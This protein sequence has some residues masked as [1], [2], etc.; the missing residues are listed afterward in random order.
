M[1]DFKMCGTCRLQKDNLRDIASRSIRTS[2]WRCDDC[3]RVLNRINRMQSRGLLASEY[4][5]LNNGQKVAFMQNAVDLF[6][7]DINRTICEHLEKY[8]EPRYHEMANAD[9]PICDITPP[10]GKRKRTI[11]SENGIV[12]AAKKKRARVAPDGKMINLNQRQRGNRDTAEQKL[13]EACVD[14]EATIMAANAPNIKPEIPSKFLTKVAE[15]A[16]GFKQIIQAVGELKEERVG[17]KKFSQWLED[18]KLAVK[19]CTAINDKLHNYVEDA[20]NMSMYEH[21]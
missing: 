2:Q 17:A 11:Q 21:E 14:L 9:Q 20:Q 1:A 4:H 7:D 19:T 10:R 3:C 12:T 18:A 5:E 16:N 8:I 13:A 6:G 15:L